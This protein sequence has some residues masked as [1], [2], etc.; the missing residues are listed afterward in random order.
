MSD[1]KP[2]FEQRIGRVKRS[3]IS[4][5]EFKPETATLAGVDEGEE[6][7]AAQKV[8]GNADLRGLL[9]A[10]RTTAIA[11]DLSR[12]LR[13]TDGEIHY[14]SAL[15]K[16]IK[17]TQYEMLLLTAPTG[18][19]PERVKLFR[20]AVKVG[21]QLG[22]RCLIAMDV[23]WRSHGDCAA[24]GHA[25]RFETL[26]EKLRQGR[27]EVLWMR[28]YQQL[29]MVLKHKLRPK[30]EHIESLRREFQALQQQ[31]QTCEREDEGRCRGQL[32]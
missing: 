25:L 12:E 22:L 5:T 23:W 16:W 29:A 6:E 21:D 27:K 31:L 2:Y 26:C 18:C 24:I 13:V 14:G 30:M 1:G 9:L 15:V 28:D 20:E 4:L 19:S 17:R 8:F 3:D 7:T 11:E 32:R 10:H